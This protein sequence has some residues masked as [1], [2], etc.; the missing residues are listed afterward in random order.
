MKA[1]QFPHYGIV[2]DLC[3]TQLADVKVVSTATGKTTYT[4]L[5][6]QFGEWPTAL[7]P[8]TVTSAAAPQLKRNSLTYFSAKAGQPVNVV[9]SNLKGQQLY[10]HN[11]V[12]ER[13]GVNSLPCE[14]SM[15]PGIQIVQC[16]INGQKYVS[17]VNINSEAPFTLEKTTTPQTTI[18]AIPIDD[19]L[20]FTAR[21][22]LRKYYP[23]PAGGNERIIA[24]LVI[25]TAPPY[26]DSLIT[27]EAE[28][29]KPVILHVSARDKSGDITKYLWGVDGGTLSD[30]TEIDQYTTTFSTTGEKKVL[31]QVMNEYEEFSEVDTL[32]V[33][34]TN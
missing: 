21:S 28:V 31:V 2:S 7:S 26:F 4:N 6:G 33:R 15:A 14:L 10:I 32:T 1:Q 3:C 5:S 19:T 12:S 20:I 23:V 30:T 29:N 17:K 27:I 22:F 25:S 18:R 34:V 9:I 24:N 16:V 11:G 8:E 13:A